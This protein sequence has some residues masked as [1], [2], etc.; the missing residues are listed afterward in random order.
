[1]EPTKVSHHVSTIG[2]ITGPIK[3]RPM[4][5]VCESAHHCAAAAQFPASAMGAPALSLFF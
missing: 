4:P 3:P 1:M 5:Q 2:H